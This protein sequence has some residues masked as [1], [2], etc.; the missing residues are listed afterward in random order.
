MPHPVSVMNETY[1]ALNK[2]TKTV[3][4]IEGATWDE[5]RLRSLFGLAMPDNSVASGIGRF[6]G[7]ID[8]VKRA[9]D[10]QG[11]KFLGVIRC[12]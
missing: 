6:P 8:G 9:A 7:D 5:V 3:A 4:A 10:K 11:M 2:Q 12:N 1:F